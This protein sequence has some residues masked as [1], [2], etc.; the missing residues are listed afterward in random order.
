MFWGR[1]DVIPW[2]QRASLVTP[3]PWRIIII[4]Q[5][6][7]CV[8]QGVSRATCHTPPLIRSANPD[9][10]IAVLVSTITAV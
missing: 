10:P 1:Q 2:Y 4:V 6:F 8:C 3:Q 9:Y 5:S 7:F